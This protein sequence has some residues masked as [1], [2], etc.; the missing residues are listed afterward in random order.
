MISSDAPGL[1]LARTRT[2]E[3]AG[4]RGFSPLAAE[5]QAWARNYRHLPQNSVQRQVTCFADTNDSRVT[6]D[7]PTGRG[8]PGR[9]CGAM[10][11]GVGCGRG[12]FQR[13][14]S[15]TDPWSNTASLVCCSSWL[16]QVAPTPTLHRRRLRRQ[17]CRRTSAASNRHRPMCHL[18]HRDGLS[19]LAQNLGCSKG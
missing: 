17:T 11:R 5:L 4:Q 2:S 19:T 16:W 10:F 12:R 8:T 14:E 13:R 15:G 9:S 18:S 1:R 6:D 7:G 3:G